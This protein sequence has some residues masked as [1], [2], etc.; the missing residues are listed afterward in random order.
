MH[1]L[2]KLKSSEPLE[3]A[4][5]S[6]DG[7]S[8]RIPMTPAPRNQPDNVEQLDIMN[9]HG[10]PRTAEELRNYVTQLQ[11]QRI[12]QLEMERGMLLA[13]VDTL[14]KKCG[15]LTG[16]VDNLEKERGLLPEKM[17]KLERERAELARKVAN[18]EEEREELTGEVVRLGQALESE[19]RKEDY[20]KLEQEVNKRIVVAE[21]NLLL[22][23][24]ANP[25]AEEKEEMELL[26]KKL[27]TVE[28][29]L[30]DARV[31]TT[32]DKK[33]IYVLK[34]K[35]AK[36]DEEV[37]AVKLQ[38]NSALQREK[39]S[40]LKIRGLLDQ[41]DAGIP[42]PEESPPEEAATLDCSM[43]DEDMVTEGTP[44]VEIA[45]LER[46]T[47]SLRDSTSR[48]KTST[49][50]LFKCTLC[51]RRY[52]YFSAVNQHMQRIHRVLCGT[53]EC[54]ICGDI[55]SSTIEFA[56]HRYIV[57]GFRWRSSTRRRKPRM[58]Q[59]KLFGCYLCP[60]SYDKLPALKIHM[61]KVHAKNFRRY[62]GCCECGEIFSSQIRL[63]NHQQKF[64]P[65]TDQSRM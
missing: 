55:F 22:L 8:D 48:W 50:P 35:V 17:D 10:F 1:R 47:Y 29:S 62:V 38:L 2:E 49:T 61:K 26:E 30:E 60:N 51:P 4:S 45:P 20:Y 53:F 41:I 23:N 44:L 25:V 31:Q 7:D 13:T 11:I 54:S 65:S 19:K 59:Q 12:N 63:S 14:E 9:S 16:K 58:V 52:P 43:T 57:H 15:S 42:I 46:P 21:L 34:I 5:S 37:K 18:L 24:Q 6:I 36:A 39:D 64:H 28:Q 40:T 33:L 27:E 3:H 56:K 32:E